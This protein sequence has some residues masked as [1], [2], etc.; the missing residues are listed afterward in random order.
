L[1]ACSQPD[2]KIDAPGNFKVSD[3]TSVSVNLSWQPVAGAR[4]YVIDR[5]SPG[6]AFQQMAFVSASSWTNS[7][8]SPNTEY[9]YRIRASNGLALGA[10]SEITHRTPAAGAV[11]TVGEAHLLSTAFGAEKLLTANAQFRQLPDPVQWL[12]ANPYAMNGD[13][14]VIFD[15]NQSN[16]ETLPLMLGMSSGVSRPAG[17]ALEF[18]D[19]QGVQVVVPKNAAADGAVQ[20]NV[21][22]G[23]SIGSNVKL[24]IPGEAGG[25]PASSLAL[26]PLETTNFKFITPKNTD[27]LTLDDVF[28]WEP[29][30]LNSVVFFYGVVSFKNGVNFSC[31]VQDDG[32]FGFESQFRDA[33]EKAGGLQGFQI[34]EYGRVV[35]V[36]SADS[37]NL[38]FAG[39][40]KTVSVLT[41][42]Q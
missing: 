28:T 25:V 21:R 34:F 10:S 33:V 42:P 35:F 24:E 17:D 31:A 16:Q 26:S 8:L 18:K 20:Y 14:C 29:K 5:K 2:N 9:T 1:A 19:D 15:Q 30:G 36:Q 11:Q 40:G 27:A 41:P 4:N 6:G 39:Q 32:D 12:A 13:R 22:K 3:L 23:G 38:V 7:Q 37:Q